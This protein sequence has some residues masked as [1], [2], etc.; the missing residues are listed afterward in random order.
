LNFNGFID[1][2][3]F[4]GFPPILFGKF[5]A[6]R[7]LSGGSAKPSSTTAVEE[8]VMPLYIL[9]IHQVNPFLFF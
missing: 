4:T 3:V 7:G 6:K 5:L 2:K 9:N 1:I 8:A